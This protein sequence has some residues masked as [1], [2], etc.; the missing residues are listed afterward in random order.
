MPTCEASCAQGTRETSGK[1][2]DWVGLA[3]LC[4]EPD[5]FGDI[6]WSLVLLGF[7]SGCW[8]K[9][10]EAIGVCVGEGCCPPPELQP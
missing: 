8:L 1:G 6:L 7:P 3:E 5:P 9:Q 4:R 10:F 2:L